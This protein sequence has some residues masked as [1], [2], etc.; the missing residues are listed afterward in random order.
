MNLEGYKG[1]DYESQEDDGELILSELPLSMIKDS[2]R[3]QFENPTEYGKNDFVQTFETRW[4]VT[5]NNMDEENE[6]EITE[7]YD[8]FI[9]FM[10]DIF[11]NKLSL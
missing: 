11:K 8:Q 9:S 4:V 2:I 5:K 3:E 1:Y 6:E 10:R 7:L